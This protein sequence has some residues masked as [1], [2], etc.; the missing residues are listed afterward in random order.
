VRAGDFSFSGPSDRVFVVDRLRGEIRFGDGLTGRLPVLLH[1]TDSEIQVTYLAGGGEGG[2]IG[3]ALEWTAIK[4]SE[5]APSPTLTGVNLVPA[6]SGAESESLADAQQRVRGLLRERN[7]AVT[8]PDYELLAETTPGV[9]FVRA[10]A[11]AGFDPEFPCQTV[12]GAISV[13]VVPY[14]S[15]EE[16]EQFD[17]DLFV[18]APQPDPGALTAAR[19]RLDGARLIGTQVHVLPPV[20]RSVWL[21]VDVSADRALSS[22]LRQQIAFRLRKFL[23]PLVG[24]S[25]GKGWPFGDPI[26]PT[27]LIREAQIVL[28]DAADVDRIWVRISGMDAA[29]NCLDVAIG[30]HELPKLEQVEVRVK[31]R[32]ALAGGLR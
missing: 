15:R 21:E 3:A 23:D 6:V 10:Y 22:T 30:A 25:D 1:G 18:P 5:A 4:G 26:R 19:T 11:Q 20:Y 24:G 7:R 8:G 27:A 9:G 28:A 14:A 16:G 29:V 13:F 31:I 32:V 12:P 17:A 2:N